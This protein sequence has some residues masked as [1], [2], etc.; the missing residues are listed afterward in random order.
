MSE[1]THRQGPAQESAER[2]ANTHTSGSG[3]GT[4]AIVAAL[5]ANLGIAI[6]KFVGFLLTGS[7]SLLAEAG[8]SVADTT[9][10]GLL[11]LGGR[12]AK[13]PQDESHPFGYGM[14]RYFWSFVVALILFS[15]GSLFAIYEG[16]KKLQ[17]PHEVEKPIIAVGILVVAVVLEAFSFRTAIIES[18]PLKGNQSWWSFIRTAKVPEL[19]VL[20]LEDSGALVGLLL[21]LGGVGMVLLTDDPVWDAY[22]TLAIGALL[23]VIAVILIIEMRSLLL[24]EAASPEAT[25][26]LRGAIESSP[27]VRRL[28]HVRTMHVGPEEL[29][30]AAKIEFDASLD[31]AGV[32]NAINETEARIRSLEPNATLIYI[33]PAIHDPMR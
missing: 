1:A 21:A 24:G 22:A 23:A 17:H 26:R 10:Q 9:N 31:F 20:L 12:Q 32:S 13:K 29:L 3:H 11:L 30:V 7:A 27:S 18:R 28:I 33:E 5:F 8:H 14:T 16:I 4:K 2:P 19:P 25:A 15:L 6:A